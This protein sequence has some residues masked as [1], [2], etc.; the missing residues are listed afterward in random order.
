MLVKAGFSVS[1]TV[2]F[3]KKNLWISLL[4]VYNYSHLLMSKNEEMSMIK[5]PH[6]LT[7]RK[8]TAQEEPL[9]Q[10]RTC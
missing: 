5:Q 6:L 1:L 10:V 7:L 2:K 8:R 4:Q 3:I 9:E